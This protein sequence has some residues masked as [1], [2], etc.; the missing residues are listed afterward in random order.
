MIQIER[1]D[2]EGFV[3]VLKHVYRR[4]QGYAIQ[5]YVDRARWHK[6]QLIDEFLTR[7]PRLHLE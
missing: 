6:G 1:G 5:L 4:L 2:R 3:K 7:H